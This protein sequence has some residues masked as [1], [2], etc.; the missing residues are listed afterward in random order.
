MK[1][2]FPSPKDRKQGFGAREVAKPSCSREVSKPN[3]EGTLA[4]KLG[5]SLVFLLLLVVLTVM[6]TQS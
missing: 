5:L 2:L 1:A 3:W 6:V 4:D